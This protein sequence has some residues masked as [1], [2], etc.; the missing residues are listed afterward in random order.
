MTDVARPREHDSNLLEAVIDKSKTGFLFFSLILSNNS[1][2]TVIVNRGA[3]TRI[4]DERNDGKCTVCR[5]VKQ[6]LSVR[7]GRDYPTL[8]FI[9][10]VGFSQETAEYRLNCENYIIRLSPQTNHR[11]DRLD[12]IP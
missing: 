4:P 7:L 6:M 1:P 9:Q 5:P 11:F 8:L 12:K 2:R 10:P 3:L